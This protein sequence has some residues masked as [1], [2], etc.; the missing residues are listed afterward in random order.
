MSRQGDLDFSI[1]QRECVSRKF[2][3]QI[4]WFLL[5]AWG[6][7]KIPMLSWLISLQY[8]NLSNLLKDYIYLKEM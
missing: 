3:P 6:A 2:S 7:V 1:I 8:K 4:L 5:V